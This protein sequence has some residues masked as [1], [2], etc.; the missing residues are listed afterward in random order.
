[1]ID[2]I[3]SREEI[4]KLVDELKFKGKIIVTINGSFDILHL[5]HLHILE[6]AK[7]QGDIL[8][9]GVNSD[10]SVR[11]WKKLMNNK[12]WS[13]RPYNNEKNRTE[14]LTGFECVDFVTIFNEV[15]C[16]K[17]V[18]SI[19]PNVHVNG[20]EYGEDCIESSLV[21]KYGGKIHII[22]LKEELSTSNLVE[23][24]KNE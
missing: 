24:I 5:G 15:D 1:M 8:I 23:K 2:K 9:I 21:K 19:K 7:Q 6:E 14:L 11:E 4:S 17:F 20:S 22:K 10:N 13:K 18:E 3:K 16:L 12:D